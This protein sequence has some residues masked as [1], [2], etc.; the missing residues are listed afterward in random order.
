MHTG[1][2]YKI[3]ADGTDK[4]YYGST[5]QI[6]KKRFSVHKSVFKRGYNCSSKKLFNFPNTRIECLETH[7][8]TDKVALKQIL[9]EIECG[10]IE[11]FRKYRPNRCV[12]INLPFRDYHKLYLETIKL[13]DQEILMSGQ[14]NKLCL[15]GIRF[16]LTE[17]RWHN[18]RIE[19]KNYLKLI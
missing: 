16:L 2:I 14:E 7:H 5:T 17:E 6:L 12:N 4:V 9:R 15:C 19:H 13:R 18:L 11:R 8:D 10:Y 3:V 1:F